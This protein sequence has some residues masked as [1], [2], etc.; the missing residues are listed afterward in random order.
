MEVVGGMGV[1]WAGLEPN[2]R[3]QKARVIASTSPC[4][5]HRPRLDPCATGAA[6]DRSLFSFFFYLFCLYWRMWVLVL[7]LKDGGGSSGSV[8]Y[9]F[10]LLLS[11]KL[12]ILISFLEV[13]FMNAN[14]YHKSHNDNFRNDQCQKNKHKYIKKQKQKTKRPFQ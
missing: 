6:A 2:N 14:T 10:F 1:K 5:G 4:S 7:L 9:F 11:F 8:G 3:Q 12:L 13:Y